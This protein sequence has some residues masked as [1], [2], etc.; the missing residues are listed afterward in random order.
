MN[1]L[2]PPTRQGIHGDSPLAGAVFSQRL[3]KPKRTESSSRNSNKNS[4]ALLYPTA[5]L[6]RARRSLM[7]GRTA[8]LGSWARI[9]ATSTT[10]THSKESKSSRGRSSS[11]AGGGGRGGGVGRRR[12][13]GDGGSSSTPTCSDYERTKTPC[14]VLGYPSKSLSFHLLNPKTKP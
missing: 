4:Y 7:E 9:A 10:I 5:M 8:C 14:E 6:V 12:G 1:I 13:G 2:D 3:S 11:G